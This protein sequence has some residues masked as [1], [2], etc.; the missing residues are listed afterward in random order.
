MFNKLALLFIFFRHDYRVQAVLMRQ[1]FEENRN[2]KDPIK[3]KQ[4]LD[5]AREKFEYIRHPDPIRCE[6]L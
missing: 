4:V 1:K 6:F 3:A 5:E 2:I